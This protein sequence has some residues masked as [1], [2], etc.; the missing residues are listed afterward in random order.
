[1]METAIQGNNAIGNATISKPLEDMHVEITEKTSHLGRD[2]SGQTNPMGGRLR[3]VTHAGMT[4]EKIL[5]ETGLF[6]RAKLKSGR[7]RVVTH[8]GKT[9]GKIHSRTNDLGLPRLIR[10][11]SFGVAIF[12]PYPVNT[13]PVERQ[14]GKKKCRAQDPD[15][16]TR[17]LRSDLVPNG[18]QRPCRN[19][20]R[21]M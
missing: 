13:K 18:Y 21:T 5:T 15:G 14:G 19:A 11:N 1:M 17:N 20:S 10:T 2:V 7:L 16:G 3:A 6:I 8:A 4:D 12:K 9:D